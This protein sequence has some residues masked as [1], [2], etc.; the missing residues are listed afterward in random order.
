[1]IREEEKKNI[2]FVGNYDRDINQQRE[3][4]IGYGFDI[5]KRKME[6]VPVVLTEAFFSFY[7]HPCHPHP[8]GSR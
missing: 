1:M 6:Y 2:C 7:S 8:G 3:T 5:H 4:G